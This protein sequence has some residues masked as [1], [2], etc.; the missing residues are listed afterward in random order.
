MPQIA[1]FCNRP[2]RS[3]SIPIHDIDK[4]RP[5]RRTLPRGDP[6]VLNIFSC[7]YDWI[8]LIAFKCIIHCQV[9]ATTWEKDIQALS[10]I[11]A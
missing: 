1:L 2:L 5:P 4:H 10:D 6:H 3:Y 8:Y 7:F 9:L 11:S